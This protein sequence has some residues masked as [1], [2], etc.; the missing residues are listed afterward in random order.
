M[1]ATNS[2]WSSKC[3]CT[4]VYVLLKQLNSK[5]CN[6]K[7]RAF[8]PS[9]NCMSNINRM[10]VDFYSDDKKKLCFICKSGGMKWLSI[11]HN[12]MELNGHVSWFDARQP[13]ILCSSL[14]F[15]S[16][17]RF[18][19]HSYDQKSHWFRLT[20]CKC[21]GIINH[22]ANERNCLGRHNNV[23]SYMFVSEFSWKTKCS[24]HLL[25]HII[26][27]TGNASFFPLCLSS[28]SDLISQN[29]NYFF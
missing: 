17:C 14:A 20:I 6:S 25:K 16:I 13:I 12:W 29:I 24:T 27:I 26:F 4:N 28:K 8:R 21:I 23:C 10:N 22:F 3:F 1:L 19:V 15:S 2:C 11:E 18:F 7:S 9:L 5:L